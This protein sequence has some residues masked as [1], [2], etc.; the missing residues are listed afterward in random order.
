MHTL[1]RQTVRRQREVGA[2]GRDADQPRRGPREEEERGD[3]QR[4]LEG[5]GEKT[6]EGRKQ[7]REERKGRRGEGE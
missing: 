2:E 5:K 1:G 6:R 7:E 4:M 3:I